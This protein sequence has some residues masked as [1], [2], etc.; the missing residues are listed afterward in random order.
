MANVF[1]FKKMNKTIR[2]YGVVQLA[3]VALLVFMA[4]NFQGKLQMEHRGFRFMHGVIA[5]FVVQL[6]LLYPIYRFAEKEVERDLTLTG[7]LSN[8]E[9]NALA[10]KK[11]IA[12]ILKISTLGFFVIFVMAAPGDTFILSVIY[13]SF[14][15]T[16][17]TYLQ[18]YN[19]AA[20]KLIAEKKG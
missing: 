13:Y 15:L 5:S 7:A 9:M 16:I 1:D 3:L 19:F 8:D 2:I 17:L 11:R 4:V 14:I 6:L 18:C 10:K 20:R 12:D